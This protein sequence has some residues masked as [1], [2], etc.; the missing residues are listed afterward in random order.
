LQGFW[1]IRITYQWRIVFEFDGNNAS[2][3]RITDYH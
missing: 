1:S 2:N 3:V